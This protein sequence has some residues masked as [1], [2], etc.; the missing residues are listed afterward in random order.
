M[1]N[2]IFKYMLNI[3]LI[4]YIYNYNYTPFIKNIINK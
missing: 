2:Y 1:I 4:K 3:Y